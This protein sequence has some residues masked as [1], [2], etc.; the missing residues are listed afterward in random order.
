MLVLEALSYEFYTGVPWQLL[1]A[2]D[3]VVVADIQGECISKLRVWKAGVE[4]KCL[5]VNMKKIK[6]VVS[7]AGHD[8]SSRNLTSTP[9]LFAVV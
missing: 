3:L 5:P 1:Y 2:Y 6:F 8:M 7:D 4:N 9:V